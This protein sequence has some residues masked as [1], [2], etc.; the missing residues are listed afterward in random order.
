M[1]MPPNPLDLATGVTPRLIWAAALLALLWSGIFW[2]MR[3]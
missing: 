3:L 1:R 2:A